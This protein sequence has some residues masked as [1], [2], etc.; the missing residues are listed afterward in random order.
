MQ[1]TQ[2]PGDMMTAEV[3]K[4]TDE[5][6]QNE[7]NYILAQH[8]TKRLLDK[9]MITLDEFNKITAKNRQSFSPLISKIIP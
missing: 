1:I 5:E 4:P 3:P 2:V 9:G 6:M 8:L 7:Y